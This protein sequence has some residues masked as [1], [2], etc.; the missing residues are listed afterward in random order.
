MAVAWGHWIH[1]FPI[2]FSSLLGIIALIG[3]MVNDGLVLVGKFN[4]NLKR[5]MQ[6][7]EAILDAGKSRFRAIFLTSATTIAGLAPLLFEKSRQAQF[8]KPMAISV[9]YGIGFATLLT[10]LILPI[11]ISVNNTIK[12]YLK[13][14][15]KGEFPSKESVERAL[16]EEDEQ[17]W[18]EEE[19]KH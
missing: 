8:L 7:K 10:L 9:A 14:L 6:F 5:G 18:I 11:Y 2:N 12:V 4:G 19:T 17:H 3:I 1:G 15:I 16:R 13:W